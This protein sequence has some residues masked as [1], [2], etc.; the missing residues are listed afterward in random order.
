MKAKILI[1]AL[2]TVRTIDNKDNIV[3]QTVLTAIAVGRPVTRPPPHRSRR[4]KLPH[5]APPWYSLRTGDTRP[6][7]ILHSEVF[8]CSPVL[9]AR[10][11][12]PN[13]DYVPRLAPSPCTRLSRAP[14][15][16][17]QSDFPTV[18]RPPSIRLARRTW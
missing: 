1:Q 14:S 11:M 6:I 10:Q 15:S 9:H 13:M 5:R 17:G 8:I 7:A 2:K 12:F 4:A 16:M 3:W 18:F